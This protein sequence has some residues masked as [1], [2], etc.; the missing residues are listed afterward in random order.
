MVLCSNDI[1]I[2][3]Y[4]YYR[5]SIIYIDVMFF[6][7]FVYFICIYT[8]FQSDQIYYIECIYLKKPRLYIDKH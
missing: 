8:T 6:I 4:Y 7:L 3:Y 5:L 1:R 2:D